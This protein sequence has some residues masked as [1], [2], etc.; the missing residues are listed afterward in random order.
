MSLD[1]K[2]QTT[3][4]FQERDLLAIMAAIIYATENRVDVDDAIG[5]AREILKKLN[6]VT[7]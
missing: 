6:A 5:A 1:A 7:P 4:K 3:M 2:I